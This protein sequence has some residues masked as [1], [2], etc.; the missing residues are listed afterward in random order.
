M[1]MALSIALAIW[2][3]VVSGCA[4]AVRDAEHKGLR[5]QARFNLVAFLFAW[6]IQIALVGAV[7]S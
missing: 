3:I 1:T 7:A 5:D 6:L 4:Y 2:P